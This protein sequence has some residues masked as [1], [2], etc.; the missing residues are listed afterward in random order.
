MQKESQ[1]QLLKEALTIIPKRKIIILA[2]ENGNRKAIRVMNRLT[3]HD[4]EFAD[5][6][7]LYRTGDITREYY[8]KESDLIF[9]QIRRII[10]GFDTTEIMAKE[11]VKKQVT[12][13]SAITINYDPK[14]DPDLILIKRVCGIK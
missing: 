2:A 7:S 12:G 8:L 10:H 9:K 1:T 11:Y 6:D 5:L 14:E 4:R 3:D 13:S